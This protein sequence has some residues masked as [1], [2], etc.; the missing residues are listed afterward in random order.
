MSTRI[1]LLRSRIRRERE[2]IAPTVETVLRQWSRV[3]AADSEIDAYLDSTALHMHAFYTGLETIFEEIARALDDEI[4]G[5]ERWHAR[6]L[7]QMTLP[8]ESTRPALLE[9]ELAKRLDAFR[10]FRHVVRNVYATN[11]LPERMADLVT[12]IT[13]LWKD[14]QDALDRFDSFLE[15]AGSP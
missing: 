14:V 10:R 15:H 2:E 4:P 13:D 3:G 12:S 8:I 6:L 9:P 5:G 1:A 11:L 7:E